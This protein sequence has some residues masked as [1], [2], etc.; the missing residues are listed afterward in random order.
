MAISLDEMETSYLIDK[1]NPDFVDC[2]S[3]DPYYVRRLKKIADKLGIGYT[4]PHNEEGSI[5]VTLPVECVLLREPPAKR[6]LSDEQRAAA[7]ERFRK[8]RENKQ[9]TLEDTDGTDE[10]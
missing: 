6:V 2:Y 4:H 1:M 10:E 8:M 5:R 3:C 7:A 9:S